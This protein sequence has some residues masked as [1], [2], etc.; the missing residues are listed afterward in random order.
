MCYAKILDEDATRQCQTKVLDE[1]DRLTKVTDGRVQK[2][3]VV[4]DDTDLAGMQ[5]LSQ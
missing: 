3:I 4:C 5:P 1:S 2:H